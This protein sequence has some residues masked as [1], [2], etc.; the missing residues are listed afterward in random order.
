MRTLQDDNQRLSASTAAPPELERKQH[1]HP[2]SEIKQLKEKR[3]VLPNELREK[4][5]L[6]SQSR[7]RDELLPLNESF[8]REVGERNFG[9]RQ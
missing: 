2:D 9:G 6:V 5:L 3:D 4:Q 8:T 7:K 1:E